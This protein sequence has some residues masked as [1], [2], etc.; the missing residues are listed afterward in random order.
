VGRIGRITTGGTVTEYAVPS[1]TSSPW[2]ITAGPDGALWFTETGG[3]RIGRIAPAAPPARAP[4]R[5]PPNLPAPPTLPGLPAVAAPSASASGPTLAGL[6]LS[7]RRFAP[8]GRRAVRGVPRGTVFRY[9]LSAPATVRIA[10]SRLRPGRRAVSAGTLTRRGTRGANRTA[11]SGRLGGRALRPGTYRAR[12][13][14][15]AGAGSS[16]ARS[17]TFRVV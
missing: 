14:A 4:G 12:V 7:N 3:N 1:A 8:V 10:L 15:T 5:V 16:A 2:G 9:R 11:F 13:T 6:S 17:V